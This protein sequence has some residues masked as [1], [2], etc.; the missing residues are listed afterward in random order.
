MALPDHFD[1]TIACTPD[2]RQGHFFLLLAPHVARRGDVQRA[3][4]DAGFTSRMYQGQHL[5]VLPDGISVDDAY[6][7]VDEQILLDLHR[8]G[9]AS[10]DLRGTTRTIE[11]RDPAGLAFVT[12]SLIPDRT[13]A[14]LVPYIQRTAPAFDLP[15]ALT[16]NHFTLAVLDGRTVFQLPPQMPEE[17]R[18]AAVLAAV[19]DLDE[20]GAAASIDAGV[21][22]GALRASHGTDTLPAFA[23]FDELDA[24][25]GSTTDEGI[26]FAVVSESLRPRAHPLLTDAGFVPAVFQDRIVYQLTPPRAAPEDGGT[27]RNEALLAAY[28]G[29]LA[30][31]PNIVN[32]ATPAYRRAGPLPDVFVD[33]TGVVATAVAR[34][35]DGREV[36]ERHGFT[37]TAPGLALQLPYLR[38]A[39]VLGTVLD[40]DTDLHL[41]G[42]RVGIDFG[43]PRLHPTPARQPATGPTPVP[44]LPPPTAGHR[45]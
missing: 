6:D 1:V 39:A 8:M 4:H 29:L 5:A 13:T 20:M 2:G 18:V 33:L 12:F 11:I 26:P 24:V 16:D 17:Q 30:L 27:A 45:R 38:P 15:A 3:L 32:L 44:C 23:L 7:A 10:V 9:F 25:L 34:H 40:V 31:S 41:A 43:M 37:L 14:M 28:Q 22:T 36:L 35:P 19:D 42:Q 21:P